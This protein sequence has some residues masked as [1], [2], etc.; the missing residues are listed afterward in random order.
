[1]KKIYTTL[2]SLIVFIGISNA[3]TETVSA[4]DDTTKIK[5]GNMTI[6]FGEDGEEDSEFDFDMEDTSEVDNDKSIGTS[7]ELGLGM[8]GWLNTAGTTTFSSDYL[9]MGLELNR[10][11][12]FSMHAMMHG[13]DIANKHLF[14]SPGIGVTWNNYHFEDKSV[15][16]TT[17]AD[18]TI[19]AADSTV[20][21]D[22]YKLRATYLEVPITIGARLGN[23]ENTHFTIEAGVIGGVNI[24]SVVKQRS[25]IDEVKFKNKIK[26]DFNVNPFKLDAIVKLRINTSIGI[27]GRYSLTTMFEQNKTQEV[28]PFSLGLTIGGI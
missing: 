23:P 5:I 27:Y 19:F 3:Q 21:F 17:G 8:N 10:S 12:A 25:Y 4:N 20:Q 28:Y 11:R 6:I 26:D 9:N 15:S 1:M 7:L 2:F 18:T 13:L 14:I 22:K 16:I 24:A